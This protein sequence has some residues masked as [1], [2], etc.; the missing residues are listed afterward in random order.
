MGGLEKAT[1]GRKKVIKK[2]EEGHKQL[3]RSTSTDV[4]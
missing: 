3:E 4:I 1:G 2:N